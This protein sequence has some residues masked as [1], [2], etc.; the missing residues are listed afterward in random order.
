MVKGT[1]LFQ[2]ISFRAGSSSMGAAI[3]A[4]SLALAVLLLGA[5]SSRAVDEADVTRAVKRG[6]EYLKRMQASNGLWHYAGTVPGSTPIAAPGPSPQDLGTTALAALALLECG[7]DEDDPLIVRAAD[8][9]RQASV[10]LTYTYAISLCI[11]FFDRLGDADDVPLIQS[12]TLRLVAGQNS[13]GGWTYNCPDINDTEEHHLRTTL[14]K[15][16]TPRGEREKGP[17]KVTYL[18]PGGE[19]RER[20]AHAREVRVATTGGVMRGDNSNT[21]FA[22]L[23]LW[24][25]RRYGVPVREALREVGDRFRQSQGEDNG[26][27]YVSAP[28]AGAKQGPSTAAITCA[29]LLGLAVDYGVAKEIEA[30]AEEQNRKRSRPVRDPLKDPRIFGALNRLAALLEEVMAVRLDQPAPGP[31]VP[32]MPGQPPQLASQRLTGGLNSISTIYYI[33]W[34]TERVAL[35]FSQEALGSKR[36]LDW[37]ERGAEVLLPLQGHDGGWTA[38]GFGTGGCPTI[39]TCFALLFLQRV[40]LA[41]DLTTSLKRKSRKSQEMLLKA[42]VPEGAEDSESG[43]GRGEE[44]PSFAPAPKLV[45]PNRNSARSPGEASAPLTEAGRLGLQLVEAAAQQQEDAVITRLRDSKGSVHTDALAFA[46]P[47]LSGKPR[48]KTRDALA[49]R[50]ARMSA[51]TLRDK[52]ADSDPEIRRAASL[53]CAMIED[54]SFLPDLIGLLRDP[55]PAV[56]PAAHASL[57][58]LTGQDFGPGPDATPPEQVRAAN[59]W[60]EWAVK[61]GLIKVTTKEAEKPPEGDKESL[62]GTWTVVSAEQDGQQLAAAKLALL[63]SK[64]IVTGDRLTFQSATHAEKGKYELDEAETPPTIKVRTDRESL[65]GIYRLDEDLLKLCLAPQSQPQPGQFT[66]QPGTKQILWVFK[67]AKP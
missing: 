20:Y 45:L 59:R 1:F 44:P 50:L 7:V 14:K 34:S 42:D 30:R 18:N 37:Y 24:V 4:G 61:I 9:L 19:M 43:P 26:W 2:P 52:L 32:L 29:G 8:Q 38:R 36:K 5:P 54:K 41:R 65:H 3:R 46:I 51:A 53:A 56:V 13:S 57:K 63:P 22:T 16:D 27:Q 40:N 49:D 31:A 35:A 23:G 58:A 33:L 47:R 11:L 12:L 66:T 39:N 21:Q 62:Q 10:R 60:Q 15:K 6:A 67:R 28:V 55:E 25:G 48:L 64:L 17:R